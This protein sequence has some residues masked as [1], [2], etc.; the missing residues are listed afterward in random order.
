MNTRE[1]TNWSFLQ[2]VPWEQCTGWETFQQAVKA[3][4]VTLLCLWIDQRLFYLCFLIYTLDVP[5][6]V[7]LCSSYDQISCFCTRIYTRSIVSCV[8]CNS[9]GCRINVV[10]LVLVTRSSMLHVYKK[11]GREIVK[12]HH[13]PPSNCPGASS[14]WHVAASFM[15]AGF[16]VT[17]IK[18]LAK[19][20]WVL[21]LCLERKKASHLQMI[22]Q[23][24]VKFLDTCYIIRKK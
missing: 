3:Y 2:S 19:K 13:T 16:Y 23:S 15:S 6:Y 1:R 9:A 21:V 10:K 14:E 11:T 22:M 12:P 24:T 20:Q 4:V 5:D 7:F 17:K 18:M 8:L